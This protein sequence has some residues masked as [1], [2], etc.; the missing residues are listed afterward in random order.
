[1]KKL[2]LGL[3]CVLLSWQAQ[4]QLTIVCD[5]CKLLQQQLLASNQLPAQALPADVAAQL[6]TT[7]HLIDFNQQQVSSYSL[8]SN[9]TPAVQAIATPADVETKVAQL[10]AQFDQLATALAQHTIPQSTVANAWQLPH[11]AYCQPQIKDWLKQQ[12]WAAQIL[13]RLYQLLDQLQPVIG[14]LK[15]TYTL[16]LET[17]GELIVQLQLIYHSQDISLDVMEVIDARNNSVPLSHS[18]LAGLIVQ[19]KMDD[20]YQKAAPYLW[21]IGYTFYQSPQGSVR[22]VECRRPGETL[23]SELPEC[24]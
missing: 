3:V 10:F 21:R 14:G 8:T 1:M 23:P 22:I 16:T 17:G 7:L 18:K 15:Q 6:P 20:Y 13:Q 12:P 11:C 2:T 9:S 4:A 24:K 5:D 19:G